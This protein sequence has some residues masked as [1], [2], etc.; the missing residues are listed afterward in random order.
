MTRR[1]KAQF[2]RAEGLPCQPA[3]F[4]GNDMQIELLLMSLP[5]DFSPDRVS[6]GKVVGMNNRRSGIEDQV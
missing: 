5:V 2:P 6:S 3:M 4:Q 1:N